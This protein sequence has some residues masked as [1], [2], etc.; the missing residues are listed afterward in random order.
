[1]NET[2]YRWTFNFH[3]VVRQHYGSILHLFWDTAIYWLKIAIFLPLS[4]SAPS[5]PMFPLEF[6]EVNREETR[7]IELSTVKTESSLSRF[8]TVPACDGRTDR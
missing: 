2:L 6:C 8:D 4:H 5:L 1:M 7:V 3:E